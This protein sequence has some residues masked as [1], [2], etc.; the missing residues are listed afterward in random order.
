MR[1]LSI[2]WCLLC[3]LGSTFGQ[4]RS[5][6]FEVVDTTGTPV[7]GAVLVLDDSLRSASDIDGSAQMR[8]APGAHR[9]AIT[10]LGHEPASGVL[11]LK[12]APEVVRLYMREARATLDMVVVSAGRYEQRIGE[13]SQSLSVLPAEILRNKNIVSLNDAMDQVPGVVVVDNDP[14]IRAGSGFS[15]GAGSRVMVLVDDLPILSGDI[16]RPSWTFLPIENVEQVEVIKGASSVLYGSAA[17]SGTINVRTAYPRATPRTRATVFGGV[18]GAPGHAPAKW[19]GDAS[20]AFTG[21]SF[22]HAQQYGRLDLVVGGNAFSDAGY[23]GPERIAPDSLAADP[24]MLKPAGF[25][26]RVRVNIA[27]RWRNGRVKGLTYGINANVMKSRSANVFIWDDTDQGLFR[28]KPGTVTTTLG[29]QYYIDPFVRYTGP[30]GMKHVLRGRLYAQDFDNDNGQANS[31]DMRFAEYQAQRRLPVGDGLNVTAGISLRSTSSVAELYRGDESGSGSNE[32]ANTA[33]YIQLDQRLFD[34][35]SLNAG[36]RY[37]SFT[38]NG[39][40]ES[41]PVF[42]GGA[43]YRLLKATYLRAAYGQGFRYPTIGERYI[44]T[45]IGQLNI[46]PS[47]DLRPERST[48]AEAGIKQGFR[49]GRFQGYADVAVFQQTYEDYVEFT[50]GVW[51]PPSLSN[52]FGLGFRSLNTGGARITGAEVEVAATGMVGAVKLD[53]LL[54]WTR[55]LPVSTT[56]D[57]VYARYESGGSNTAYSYASTSHDTTDHILKFRVQELFRADV[58][59]KWKRLSVGASTRYNSHVRNIDR[60]FVDLD[61][62]WL[63]VLPTGVGQWMRDHTTGDWIIDARLGFDLMPQLRASIIVNNLSNEVYAL[64]PMAIEAPRSWQVQLMLDL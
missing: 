59:M 8:L 56:P 48:N 44:R 52:L 24:N 49:M 3:M 5:Y 50:F 45:S 7:V 33:G 51:A 47:P 62:G 19:W 29:T 9:Y 11:D 43:V 36:A 22:V 35:L 34:R 58:Q 41:T 39:R 32:A 1:S 20:P 10:A 26:D 46:Y 28:P 21:A 14:Q 37:E 12:E 55:A 6:R 57:Q 63:P 18:Y 53:V 13:V 23:I 54:G 60:A 31:N 40:T 61:E 64:R 15:Y 4:D 27:T 25:E 2:L 38:V 30:R 17:L 42:R 16:G